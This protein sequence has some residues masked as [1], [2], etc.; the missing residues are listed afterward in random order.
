MIKKFYVSLLLSLLTACAQTELIT[1]T[2]L[3][4][5]TAFTEDVKQTAALAFLAY[6]GDQLDNTDSKVDEILR[7]CMVNELSRQYKILKNR[8]QLAWGPV[9]YRFDLAFLDDNMMYAVSDS[10]EPGHIVIA[11]RGT[12]PDA[13]LDWFV[14]DFYVAK[15]VAWSYANPYNS[16]ARISEATQIG[17]ETLQGLKS[18]IS[19]LPPQELGIQ[20]W[21]AQLV[22]GKQLN[23]LTVTGHSLAGALAPVLALWLKDTQSS[24]NSGVPIPINVL[25]IAG[26]TPGNAEFA[27]YYNSKLGVTT[28]RMH[29][30]FDVVPKAWYIPTMQKLKTLYVAGGYNIQ[31]T[32]LEQFAFNFGIEMAQDKNYTQIL[33]YQPAISGVINPNAHSKGSLTYTAQAGWQHHCGYYNA[34]Q[35]TQDIYEVNS[36]C[37]TPSYCTA[38]PFDSKCTALKKHLCTSVSSD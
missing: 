32:A 38:N 17:L 28:N 9:A 23:K 4:Q 33:Q 34:M 5:S 3:G 6:T 11:I 13:I 1:D 26:A 7:G 16:S 36:Y 21:L 19:T 12:N 10:R 2:T 22:R 29:N 18:K 8:F 14:E 35:I 27:A 25:P 20:E 31:P 24:W 30:P 15:T 37:V